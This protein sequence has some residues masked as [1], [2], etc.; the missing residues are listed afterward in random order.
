MGKVTGFM[1]VERLE[2]N[3]D[4]VQKRVKDYREFVIR[5]DNNAAKAQASR[6][7]DCG[8]PFLQPRVSGQ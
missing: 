3:Y 2:E 5:L 8:T 7:M 6:C 4:P 1:E